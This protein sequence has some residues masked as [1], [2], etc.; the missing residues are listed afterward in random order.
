IAPPPIVLGLPAIAPPPIATAPPPPA[1]PPPPIAAPPVAAPPPPPTGALLGA[2]LPP[3]IVVLP[4]PPIVVAA[5]PPLVIFTPPAFALFI[6]PPALALPSIG[7]G[8]WHGGFITGGFGAFG[9]TAVVAHFGHREFDGRVVG[10]HGRP[11]GPSHWAWGGGGHG[12]W[13][14]GG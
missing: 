12:G 3:P 1:A 2:A 14:R 7:P 6:G 10:F 13:H 9:T 4:P 5:A 8:W 11:P